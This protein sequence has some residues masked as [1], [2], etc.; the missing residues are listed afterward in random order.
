MQIAA[1]RTELTD[2]IIGLQQR[3]HALGQYAPEAWMGLNL[4]IGQL[5]S[6][7]FID[8]QDSTNFRK[9]ADALGVTPPDVTRIVDRLVE[10]RLVSRRRYPEDRRVQLLQVTQ[11]GKALLA[12]LREYRTTRLRRILAQLSTEE[13]NTVAQGLRAL[14]KAAG[15]QEE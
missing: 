2:E 14:I 3:S 10:Q 13:L 15:L 7:F 11:K 5:K 6:L 4:T 9:L 1:Q 12:G 8:S